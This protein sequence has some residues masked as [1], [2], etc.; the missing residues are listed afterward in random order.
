MIHDAYDLSFYEFD[1]EKDPKEYGVL[2]CDV[3]HGRPPLKPTYIGIGWQWYYYGFRWG[4]ETLSLPSTHGWDS[5]FVNG[6]PYIT[7]IRTTQEEASARA[8]MFREKIKPFL[9]DFDSVWD[10]LKTELIQMYKTARASRGLKEWKDIERLS[11]NDLLSFFLDF[12]YII[13]RK[14][15][16]THMIMLMA[17]YYMSGM[18]QQVWRNLFGVEAA[19]D[20]NFTSLMGGEENANVRVTKTLWQL[21]RQ[22]IDLGL[23]PIIDATEND[24][25]VLSALAKTADGRKWL[26]LFHEF[27]L[28]DGW[29]C[30]R[31]HAYDT[32]AW[33]EK[34]GI[35]INKMKML[36]KSD[37]FPFDTERERVNKEREAAEKAV[38][39]KCPESQKEVLAMLIK[40]GQNASHWSEDHTYYCDFYIGAMGRWIINEFGMRFAAAGCIDESDDV[41]FLHPNEIRK[42]AIP[43]GKINLRPYVERRKKQFEEYSE[44]E[45]APFYGDIEQAQ[46]ILQSDPTLSVSTQVP[47]IR[48]ELKADL[49]GAAGAPGMAEG[50][51]RVIMNAKDL[52][53]IQPGEILVAPGTSAA[54]TV[55]FSIIKGLVTDGGGALSH[56]VIMA[57]QFGVPAVSGTVEATQKIKT[58]QRIVVDG[59]QGVVYILDK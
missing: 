51:A 24:D 45:P 38:M 8:P 47:I 56:P 16:E 19:I 12:A 15:G 50:I 42:A 40:G 27:L 31:M 21:G 30:E 48:K 54:W 28:E 10:P 26:D 6:Y 33:I 34:P 4:A 3:V 9:E 59:N 23:Q 39:A 17:V 20:P 22:A 13:N 29:R 7:A 18:L 43:M 25:A 32:A 57:R 2:L 44:M 53:L 46:A 1:D 35:A 11:N 49:Y 52:S 37:V 5:R 36:M 41:F 58:G 55:V 14:E